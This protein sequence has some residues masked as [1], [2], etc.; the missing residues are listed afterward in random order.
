M[1]PSGG[2]C[3]VLVLYGAMAM[4]MGTLDEAVYG[5]D[6]AAVPGL[7]YLYALVRAMQARRMGKPRQAAQSLFPVSSISPKDIQW[8]A[9]RDDLSSRYIRA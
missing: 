5:P 6:S 9:G 4:L 7:E 2:P 1:E 8:V 3:S